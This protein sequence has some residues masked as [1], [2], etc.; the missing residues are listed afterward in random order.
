MIDGSTVCKS[1]NLPVD[2]KHA[3]RQ[4]QR[5]H[6]VQGICHGLTF[7]P[8]CQLFLAVIGTTPFL[9]QLQTFGNQIWSQRFVFIIRILLLELVDMITFGLKL[10]SFQGCQVSTQ[11]DIIKVIPV[12]CKSETSGHRRLYVRFHPHAY[13]QHT[14]FCPHLFSILYQCFK[15]WFHISSSDGH[16][17]G[18][19]FSRIETQQQVIIHHGIFSLVQE[20]PTTQIGKR[21]VAITTQTA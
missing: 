9:F 19:F 4:T 17:V 7:C 8:Q 2:M 14:Q 12:F 11:V 18:Q 6:M 20:N 1:G 13:P 15:N 5:L 10:L 21:Q 3:A 16:H